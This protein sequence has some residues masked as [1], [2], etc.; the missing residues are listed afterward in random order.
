MIQGPPAPSRLLFSLFQLFQLFTLLTIPCQLIAPAQLFTRL[1]ASSLH[2]PAQLPSFQLEGESI[3]SDLHRPGFLHLPTRLSW[4]S[5]RQ[6]SARR[7]LEHT[8]TFLYISLID[9]RQEDP[10]AHI[11]ISLHFSDQHPR[12]ISSRPSAAVCPTCLQLFLLL[13]TCSLSIDW[14]YMCSPCFDAL[15]P[16]ATLGWCPT[17]DQNQSAVDTLDT[18]L[19]S[20][21]CQPA[22]KMDMRL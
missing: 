14:P 10:G 21:V 18:Q 7:T 12:P 6:T 8:S 16:A 13:Y 20:W 11:Y 3:S 9:I 22:T 1:P 17:L 5:F 19:T 15:P 4:A 2:L